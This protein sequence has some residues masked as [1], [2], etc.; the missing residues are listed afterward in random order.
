[1]NSGNQRRGTIQSIA[2]VFT[3]RVAV[4]LFTV[5]AT[6]NAERDISHGI[7]SVW[8]TREEV[9]AL[10]YSASWDA[11]HYLHLAFDGY[12]PGDES[13]AFYPLWPL[14]L[15]AVLVSV[16]ATKTTAVWIGFVLANTLGIA[17]VLLLGRL[18]QESGGDE[19]SGHSLMLF[20]V[21]PGAMFLSVIYSEPLC[22][23]LT[24]V[25]FLGLR[26]ERWSWVVLAGFLLP[27]S[28][29]VG[30]FCLAPLAWR[31]LQRRTDWRAWA[32]CLAPLV[33]YATYFLLMWHWTGN[34]F[35]GFAAQ[36]HYPNQPSLENIANLP[37]FFHSFFN[38][39]SVFG[40]LDGGLDRV[41]F[42]LLLFTLPALWRT[43]KEWFW[44]TVC[45][46][47]IPAMSNW[48]F[49]YRRFLVV[50][51]PVFFIWGKWLSPPDRRWAFWYYVVLSAIVQGVLLWRY[52][53]F[54][55]AG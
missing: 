15:N 17:S 27:L 33:G 13:C 20:C 35:E 37:Q 45:V 38:V 29:A 43:N 49:S 5:F 24:A 12:K 55:W 7:R 40:M 54:I 47:I 18:F 8:P 36:K 44:W 28:R 53:N 2:T 48:F 11:A 3:F 46:G 14:T 32:A 16:C 41:L 6:R 31:A 23:L 22:L 30:V 26:R 19:W 9:S 25:F 42:V 4:V 1:M 39:G 21:A 10:S 50:A 51:F 52:A 34:A